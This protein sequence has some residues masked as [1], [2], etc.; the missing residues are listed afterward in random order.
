MKPTN[1]IDL[2]ELN[3]DQKIAGYILTILETLRFGSIEIVVH[4]GRIVQIERREKFRF[5]TG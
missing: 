3:T 5:K 1:C 4:D 2:S